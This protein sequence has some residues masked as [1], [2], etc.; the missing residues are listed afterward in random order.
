MEE[1]INDVEGIP[2]ETLQSTEGKDGEKYIEH[3]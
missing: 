1:K 3:L 2:I